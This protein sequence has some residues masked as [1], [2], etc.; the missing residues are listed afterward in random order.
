MGMW[1]IRHMIRFYL[2]H[3][4][5]I[6]QRTTMTMK[7]GSQW[8]AKNDHK[9]QHSFTGIQRD[10]STDILTW[11]W[12]LRC[13]QSSVMIKREGYVGCD[14]RPHSCVWV[15]ELILEMVHELGWCFKHLLVNDSGQI[16]STNSFNSKSK[17]FWPIFSYSKAFTF[18][19]IWSCSFHV[20]VVVLLVESSSLMANII[21]N[22]GTNANA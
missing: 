2:F 17:C 7:G 11:T 14:G 13:N 9:D 4:S 3:D 1:T 22:A 8:K 15:C 12:V 19:A 18:V 6:S 10:L 21:K 5:Q 16:P 20:D